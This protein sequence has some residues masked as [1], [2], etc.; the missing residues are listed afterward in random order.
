MST[1]EP[2]VEQQPS[3]TLPAVLLS[4][5]APLR[6]PDPTWHDAAQPS[7]HHRS[8]RS[9]RAHHAPLGGNST[10]LWMDLYTWGQ[11]SGAASMLGGRSNS[12]GESPHQ[13]V[14]PPS[15]P[16]PARTL[17]AAA[18][19]YTPPAHCHG[20]NAS[21]AYDRSRNVSSIDVHLCSGTAIT[22]TRTSQINPAGPPAAPTWLHAAA[23]QQTL[24]PQHSQLQ[25]PHTVL[26]PAVKALNSGTQHQP[27]SS[28]QLLPRAS[29]AGAVATWLQHVQQ[30]PA[31]TA[32]GGCRG[33]PSPSCRSHGYLSAQQFLQQ[34]S[35][36][37]SASTCL[38]SCQTWATH[39]H[40]AA[41]ARTCSI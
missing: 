20:S 32:A 16:I 30:V 13:L 12:G 24:Q 26:G 2:S 19:G 22:P 29:T 17:P 5:Q 1:E 41:P 21:S 35:A 34:T 39:V 18:V 25:R 27:L 31:G 11:Q 7:A 6:P 40:P 28:S 14:S 37:I 4:P 15:Q 23:G 3:S 8:S 38:Q 36:G 10:S 33:N 9:G